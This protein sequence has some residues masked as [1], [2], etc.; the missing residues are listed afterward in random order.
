MQQPSMRQDDRSDLQRDSEREPLLQAPER[1][2]TPDQA[3]SVT[4][5]DHSGLR[6]SHI[7][8]IIRFAAAFTGQQQRREQ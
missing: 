5:R 7:N 2:Y 1:S 6:W 3:S 8:S 4:A